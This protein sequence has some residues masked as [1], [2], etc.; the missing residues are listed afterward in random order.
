[1]LCL[2]P[3]S[4]LK[5]STAHLPSKNEARRNLPSSWEGILGPSVEKMGGQELPPGCA[6]LRAPCRGQHCHPEAATRTS[7]P[8]PM[9]NVGCGTVAPFQVQGWEA[10]TIRNASL[11]FR[12]GKPWVFWGPAKTQRVDKQ[13]ALLLWQ[14]FLAQRTGC[15]SER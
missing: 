1:M 10:Q 7:G 8:G 11:W 9:S 3:G 13:A 5:I 14:K 2:Q 6:M 4:S 15:S 12:R